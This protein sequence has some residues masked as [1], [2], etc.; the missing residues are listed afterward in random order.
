MQVQFKNKSKT[1]LQPQ[2]Y[3]SE[4]LEEKETSKNKREDQKTN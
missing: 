2:K 4:S 3:A 1:K